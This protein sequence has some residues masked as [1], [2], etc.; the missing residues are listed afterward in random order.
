M[1]AQ[2]ERAANWEAGE[3]RIDLVA[4]QVVRAG[5]WGALHGDVGDALRFLQCLGVLAGDEGE[6]G[7]QAARRWLRV[8]TRLLCFMI[9]CLAPIEMET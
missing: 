1:I 2:G 6:E 8:A 7:S 3:Q 9:S 4:L 5:H